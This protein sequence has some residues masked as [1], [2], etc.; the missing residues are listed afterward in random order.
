MAN[1]DD[2]LSFLR[3]ASDGDGEIAR[4]AICNALQIINDDRMYP[5]ITLTVTE[6]GE[7]ES[8]INKP[9]GRVEVNIE[10]ATNSGLDVADVF[11]I[12]EN[13]VFN[14]VDLFGKMMIINQF[15]VNIQQQ[16]YELVD[17]EITENGVYENEKDGCAYSLI[18]VNI[19]SA[20]KE[21]DLLSPSYYFMAEGQP[22]FDSLQYIFTDSGILFGRSADF[23]LRRLPPLDDILHNGELY[24]HIG[25][26]PEIPLETGLTSDQTFLPVWSKAPY[27]YSRPTPKTVYFDSDV[28]ALVCFNNAI[29]Y[30]VKPGDYVVLNGCAARIKYIADHY[31]D[32]NH[33]LWEWENIDE[34]IDLHYASDDRYLNT[35][36]TINNSGDYYCWKHS[37][38]RAFFNSSS[39]DL[40]VADDI[41]AYN[42][43]P[44]VKNVLGDVLFNHI[45]PITQYVNYAKERNQNSHFRSY[46]TYVFWGPYQQNYRENYYHVSSEDIPIDP[47]TGYRN[48]SLAGLYVYVEKWD[49]VSQ[50]YIRVIEP[51]T[52][53]R[54]VNEY[55]KLVENDPEYDNGYNVN[56]DY[57]NATKPFDNGD[58]FEIGFS[59]PDMTKRSIAA[60]IDGGKAYR[61]GINGNNEIVKQSEYTFDNHV[62]YVIQH[63]TWTKKRSYAEENTMKVVVDFIAAYDTYYE[64]PKNL[65]LYYQC[66]ADIWDPVTGQLIKRTNSWIKCVDEEWGQH[67]LYK[68][69]DTWPEYPDVV[70]DS[71]Y[72][73]KRYMFAAVS[74]EYGERHYNY[75]PSQCRLY[76][77][78]KLPVNPEPIQ[79]KSEF[80]FY[81]EDMSWV[82]TYETYRVTDTEW[83]DTYEVPDHE[84][85]EQTIE[86]HKYFYMK[87]SVI[88]YPEMGLNYMGFAY[89]SRSPLFYS[90]LPDQGAFYKAFTYDNYVNSFN[91]R[92]L[93]NS[94]GYDDYYPHYDINSWHSNDKQVNVNF[95]EPT[96]IASIITT[97]ETAT[98]DTEC[99]EPVEPDYYIKE[100]SGEWHLP[101]GSIPA[102]YPFERRNLYFAPNESTS[103][104][105]GIYFDRIYLSGQDFKL[106][107]YHTYNV[108][109]T[110]YSSSFLYTYYQTSITDPSEARRVW[111]SNYNSEEQAEEYNVPVDIFVP[112][113]KNLDSIPF[114]KRILVYPDPYYAQRGQLYYYYISEEEMHEYEYPSNSKETITSDILKHYFVYEIMPIEGANVIKDGQTVALHMLNKYYSHFDIRHSGYSSWDTYSDDGAENIYNLLKNIDPS[115]M[116][117]IY[118]WDSYGITE[119]E[120][121]RNTYSNV[122]PLD[123]DMIYALDTHK[124]FPTHTGLIPYYRR[125]VMSHNYIVDGDVYPNEPYY[126][127]IQSPMNIYNPF[128]KNEYIAYDNQYD[129]V[130]Y[131]DDTWRRVETWVGG[132]TTDC[133]STVGKDSLKF[134]DIRQFVNNYCEY[135]VYNYNLNGM[136]NE[137]DKNVHVTI[138]K[139]V[140]HYGNESIR[141]I[142]NE[143][144]YDCEEVTDKFLLSTEIWTDP[145]CLYPEYGTGYGEDELV[146]DTTA[147][148]YQQKFLTEFFKQGDT[149][150]PIKEKQQNGVISQH[151]NANHSYR[152]GSKE[153]YMHYEYPKEV[154]DFTYGRMP[155]GNYPYLYPTKQDCDDLYDSISDYYDTVITQKKY[156]LQGSFDATTGSSQIK[157]AYFFI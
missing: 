99:P 13:G 130:Y 95:L 53:Q 33:S 54:V 7:Y 154:Y 133:M 29:G 32:I 5:P 22:N 45:H 147:E 28:F 66:Y 122:T 17:I 81:A 157:H 85:P 18:K 143:V 132:D 108:S 138:P 69:V 139:N 52:D 78:T 144:M 84:D 111:N 65:N 62:N 36:Y 101:Y 3:S 61:F 128:S 92:S 75:N 30:F 142:D 107:V 117:Y 77:A 63:G 97:E 146:L 140:L 136:L 115:Q 141:Y 64:S 46:K 41:A 100:R 59:N 150:L 2:E 79:S 58:D 149:P 94:F 80:A 72:W 82:N 68:T 71:H 25:W 39:D 86:K 60:Y 125:K 10:N 102:S 6:N 89:Y 56:V 43:L 106:D 57:Y 83:D 34:V 127:V 48:P 37:Y 120:R 70:E 16:T 98:K 47:E 76:D 11:T 38:V 156:E 124:D 24:N 96:K 35:Q 1:I 148:Y 137:E 51:T 121:L 91:D 152:Y 27:T 145:G 103:Y 116:Q 26:N 119:Y 55:Y 151:V 88:K 134:Y 131:F 15:E 135:N 4:E 40:A 19:P 31:G 12:T 67:D 49:E 42:S 123:Y 44:N 9:F 87:L 20:H 113:N 112:N 153:D 110:R 50:K 155:G 23:V 90:E 73:D 104:S 109:G 74:R 118:I 129:D 126:E 93:W 14:S 105:V 8:D 21:G 114:F